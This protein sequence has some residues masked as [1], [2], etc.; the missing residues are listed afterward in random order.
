[1]GPGGSR[2]P[3]GREE[4]S[5]QDSL[6]KGSLLGSLTAHLVPSPLLSGQNGSSDRVR[7]LGKCRSEPGTRNGAKNGVQGP[8]APSLPQPPGNPE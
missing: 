8:P 2:G 4:G 1:M 3:C 5:L 6:L 7:V